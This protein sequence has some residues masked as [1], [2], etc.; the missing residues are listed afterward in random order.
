MIYAYQFITFITGLDE[1]EIVQSNHQEQLKA[2]YAEL[3]NTQ[4]TLEMKEIDLV[5]QKKKVT[6][7]YFKYEALYKELQDTKC[8]LDRKEIQY[9]ELQ[10]QRRGDIHNH[11]DK[12]SLG[13]YLLNVFIMSLIVYY[14]VALVNV[15]LPH[16]VRDIFDFND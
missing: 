11:K 10:T 14:L 13:D 6:Q 8:A 16:I 3:E 4:N 1:Y 15:D 12:K 5:E 2:A 9:L 7:N